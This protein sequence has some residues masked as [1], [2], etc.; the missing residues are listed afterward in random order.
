MNALEAATAGALTGRLRLVRMQ[1]RHLAAHARLCADPATMR[2][3]GAGRALSNAEAMA[4]GRTMLDHWTR[5]GYGPLM[6]EKLDDGALIGRTGLWRPPDWKEPELIWLLGH[7][8]WG[9]GYGIEAVQAAR[10]VAAAQWRVVCPVSFIH[11]QNLQSLRLA[12]RVDARYEREIDVQG[13]SVQCWRHADAEREGP[14][15]GGRPCP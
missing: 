5:L 1:E 10:R 13:V 14:D 8:W 9:H 7:Q 6:I 3:V 12:R 15:R 2:F 11:P 4:L